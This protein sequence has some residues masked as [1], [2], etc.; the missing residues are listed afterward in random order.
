MRKF[1]IAGALFVSAM[2]TAA[3]AAQQDF[4]VTNHT[5]HVIMTLNVS[6]SSST[7]WGPDILGREVLGDGEQAEVSFDRNEDQCS[8]DIRVTYD[9]GTNNDMRGVNLCEVSE[10]EF[11]A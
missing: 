11:T 9:D 6:P 10:V 2:S 8:W 1:L 4:T 3:F 5:G 7:R